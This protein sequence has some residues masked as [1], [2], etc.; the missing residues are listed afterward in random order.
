MQLVAPAAVTQE[1][2]GHPGASMGAERTQEAPFSRWHS[3]S[4]EDTDLYVKHT[5]RALEGVGWG[6][7]RQSSCVCAN[8][9]V[10]VGRVNAQ[11]A[12]PGSVFSQ[13]TLTTASIYE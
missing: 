12:F 8:G 4:Y 6:G 7:G 3:M 2:G 5:A 10:Q 9:S 11:R 1:W 13:L